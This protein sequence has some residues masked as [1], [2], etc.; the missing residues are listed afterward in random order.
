MSL[1]RVFTVVVFLLSLSA[2]KEDE[3][4]GKKYYSADPR[5]IEAIPYVDKQ[6]IAFRTN[7]GDDFHAGVKR[8]FEV[9]RS[10]FACD[11]G[12]AVTLNTG[13]IRPYMEFVHRGT[14]DAPVIQILIFPERNNVAQAALVQILLTDDGKM[15][16][17]LPNPNKK[18][19][20]YNTISIDGKT[21]ADVVEIALIKPYPKSIAQ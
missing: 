18:S 21:Y 3:C 14:S 10:D 17:Y 1:Q 9:D 11:E 4:K 8:V 2:C 7:R 13:N 12:L 19:V 16:E 6:L 20:Y 5:V 15:A